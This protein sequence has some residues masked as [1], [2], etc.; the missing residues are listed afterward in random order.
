VEALD[1][2]FEEKLRLDVGF[3]RVDQQRVAALVDRWE[4][5]DGERGRVNPTRPGECRRS[6]YRSFASSRKQQRSGQ[7]QSGDYPPPSP[8]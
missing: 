8:S 4:P 3:G 7:N 5:L 6:D 1:V 2:L